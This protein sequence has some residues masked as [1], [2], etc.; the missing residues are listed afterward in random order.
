MHK[1][2][3]GRRTHKSKRNSTGS[4]PA[5]PRGRR[6]EKR[7]S[8]TLSWIAQKTGEVAFKILLSA[9]IHHLIFLWGK[10]LGH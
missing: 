2:R 1:Q 6:V 8:G 9:A 7:G 4:K 5:K 3:R 10:S